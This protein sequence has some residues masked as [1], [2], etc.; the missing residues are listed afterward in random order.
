MVGRGERTDAERAEEA[1]WILRELKLT[2]AV[3]E[4]MAIAAIEKVSGNVC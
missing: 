3:K 2:H 1:K 4:G